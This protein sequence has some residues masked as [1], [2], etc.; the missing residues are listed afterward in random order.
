[1]P[2]PGS[3]PQPLPLQQSPCFC[4]DV[5]ESGWSGRPAA[6]SLGP[7]KQP[8]GRAADPEGLP[9]RPAPEAHGSPEQPAALPSKALLSAPVRNGERLAS[10]ILDTQRPLGD[11]ERSRLRKVQTFPRLLPDGPEAGTLCLTLTPT[12]N[13]PPKSEVFPPDPREAFLDGKN[14]LSSYKSQP[15]SRLWPEREPELQQGGPGDASRSGDRVSGALGWSP[16]E[17]SAP[18]RSEEPGDAGPEP[19]T[20]R[21]D[22]G[23]PDRAGEPA[24]A[25]GEQ[26]GDRGFRPTWPGRGSARAHTLLSVVSHAVLVVYRKE[27]SL[28]LHSCSVIY[29]F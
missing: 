27:G 1:M 24:S 16:V 23:T 12:K 15:K 14:G 3:G 29:R 25:A 13:Q 9:Q 19:R 5:T 11:L 26:V 17:E 7:R 6:G 18:S 20:S 10:L 2:T 21:A 28:S 4:L 22:E 8:G